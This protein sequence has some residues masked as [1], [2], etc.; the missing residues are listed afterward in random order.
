MVFLPLRWWRRG[1]FIIIY[2]IQVEWFSEYILCNEIIYVVM[3]S[4]FRMIGLLFYKY[5]Y[6]FAFIIILLKRRILIFN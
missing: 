3:F 6:N 2:K 4:H 1:C 5:N